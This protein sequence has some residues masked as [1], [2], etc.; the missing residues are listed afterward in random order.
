MLLVFILIKYK[1]NLSKA[2]PQAAQEPHLTQ[3]SYGELVQMRAPKL[4]Q[5]EIVVG[6]GFDR[7]QS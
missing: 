7:S 1:T 4:A 5:G 3:G 2:F 6:G